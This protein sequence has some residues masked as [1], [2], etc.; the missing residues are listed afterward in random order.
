M[1]TDRFPP[2]YDGRKLKKGPRYGDSDDDAD[3]EV[4]EGDDDDSGD[5]QVEEL[6]CFPYSNDDDEL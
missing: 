3:A 6:C 4:D 2:L 5:E 1:S